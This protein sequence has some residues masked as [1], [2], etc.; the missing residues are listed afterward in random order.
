M[1]IRPA[2]E[3]D[4]ISRMRNIT[5]PKE[6]SSLRREFVELI[7]GLSD[8]TVERILKIAKAVARMHEEKRVL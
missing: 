7:D 4:R 2:V 6:R 5:V 3:V 1:W 8:D